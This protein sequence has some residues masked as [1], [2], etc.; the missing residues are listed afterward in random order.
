M[1]TADRLAVSGLVPVAGHS[2]AVG[3]HVD[4]L[5]VRGEAQ[6]RLTKRGQTEG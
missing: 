5:D 3:L 2:L 6:Q 4:L 1:S